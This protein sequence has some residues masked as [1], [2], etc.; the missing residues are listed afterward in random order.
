G[1]DRGDVPDV[2][3]VEAGAAQTLAIL[4][5]DLPRLARELH[6]EVQHGALALVEPRCAIVHHHH[7]AQHGIAELTHGIAM[8]SD[9]VE[10]SV[11][12]RH[13]GGDHLD[14]ELG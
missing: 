12:R 4:L 7:L 5:L 2:T 13:Y 6:R 14:L 1:S 3:I 8:G 10:A 11:L 9:A